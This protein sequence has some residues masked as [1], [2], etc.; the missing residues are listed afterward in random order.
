M[1]SILRHYRHDMV[2]HAALRAHQ[3]L[4]AVVI[5]A[6]KGHYRHGGGQII[7]PL[8]R[9]LWVLRGHARLLLSID[10]ASRRSVREGDPQV[11]TTDEGGGRARKTG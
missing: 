3:T 2:V 10:V 11:A 5:P 1:N 6:F 4:G 8:N 7:G 9:R